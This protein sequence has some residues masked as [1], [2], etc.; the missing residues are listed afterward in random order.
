MSLRYQLVA[1][2]E[3]LGASIEIDSI[4]VKVQSGEIVRLDALDIYLGHSDLAEPGVEFDAN[5]ISG[6][7]T[8][9]YDHDNV[10]LTGV[11][12]EWLTIPLDQSFYYNGSDNLII[13][14]AWPSGEDA[15]YAWGWIDTKNRSVYGEFDVSSGTVTDESL[16][17]RLNG[18][19]YA[20]SPAT[21]GS[22]KATLGI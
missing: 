6:T 1:Y 4:S 2:S 7:K 8:H 10:T 3:E 21:F 5:Y 16:L 12:G 15:I 11:A 17:M 13:E 20:L 18:S 14:F 9:V 22:I 19:P